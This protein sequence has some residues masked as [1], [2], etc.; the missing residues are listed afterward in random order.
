MKAKSSSR[1]QTSSERD[2]PVGIC[3]TRFYNPE[4]RTQ[5]N[6]KTARPCFYAYIG[7]KKNYKAKR[8]MI[9]TLGRE[10]ALREAK[11]WRRE[12]EREMA[13]ATG[14]AGAASIAAQAKKKR[15]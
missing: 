13:A 15:S 3:E 7:G 2:L 11:K 14:P 12:Q 5:K 10:K 6:P 1:S 8:F 9:D 4:H